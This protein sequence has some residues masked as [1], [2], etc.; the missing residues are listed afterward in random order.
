MIDLRTNYLGF[1]LGN[2][3]VA[4]SSPLTQELDNI[5]RLEDAGVAA[6]VMHSLFEEQ[7]RYESESLDHHLDV[8]AHSHPEAL[9]YFPDLGRYNLGPEGYLEMIRQAKEAVDVPIIASLNGSTDGG[10]VEYSRLIQEA[11][12]DALELNI[13]FLPTDLSLD[14]ATIEARYCQLVRH[15]RSEITIPL[16]VKLCPYFT[17][18]GRMLCELDQAGA[19][20]LVLFNRFYQPDFDLE[21]LEVVPNLHLSVPDELRLRLLWVAVVYGHVQADLAVTGGVH[22]AEDVLK[23]MM[24]GAKVAMLTSA[25]FQH[26]IDYLRTLRHNLTV[27]MEEHEYESIRQMQGSMSRQA[28][29]DPEEFDRA[30][31]ITVLGSYEVRRP[32]AFWP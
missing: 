32:A 2:P 9:T 10:W 26:G 8:G 24:A 31:Y 23:A 21:K 14:S 20:G 12:A 22:S 18:T 29:G 6:I 25:L 1:E 16:A 13:Y 17:A 28:L 27:W 7:I 11:G 5:R 19:D 3:L 30:N 15:V 4:S